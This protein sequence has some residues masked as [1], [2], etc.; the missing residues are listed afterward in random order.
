MGDIHRD[1]SAL[2][3]RSAGAGDDLLTVYEAA[4]ALSIPKL[5]IYR[6]VE[7]GELKWTR[8]GDSIRIRQ[9]SIDLLLREAI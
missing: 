9:R 1:P 4:A 5:A 7:C 2:R 6:L 8:Y 3:F